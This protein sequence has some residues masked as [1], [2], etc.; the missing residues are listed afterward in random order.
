[1]SGWRSKLIFL[2]IVYFAGFATAIYTLAPTPQSDQQATLSGFAAHP[3]D[4]GSRL[5]SAEFVES[6]NAGMHKCVDFGK[7]AALRMAK[8]LKEKIK[9]MRDA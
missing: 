8:F 1:M 5:T 6:F 3:S 9:E 2:L 7:E 4:K